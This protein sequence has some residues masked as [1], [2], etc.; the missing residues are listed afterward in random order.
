MENIVGQPIVESNLKILEMM[1]EIEKLKQE[2]EQLKSE[3]DEWKNDYIILHNKI[4]NEECIK[5]EDG[6]LVVSNPSLEDLD[7]TDKFLNETEDLGYD[8]TEMERAYAEMEKN[9]RM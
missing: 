1:A 9:Y 2:N 8:P 7:L 3:R 6:K 5:F 4:T